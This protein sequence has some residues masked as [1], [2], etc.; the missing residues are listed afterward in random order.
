MKYDIILSVCVLDI[1]TIDCL[2]Y[3]SGSTGL[4]TKW[5]KINTTW[6]HGASSLVEE[7]TVK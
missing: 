4:L 3:G 7:D 2:F 5:Q 1:Q 6:F